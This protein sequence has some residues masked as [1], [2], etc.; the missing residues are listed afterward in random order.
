M[1]KTSSK[2]GH[3]TKVQRCSTR[4][5]SGT[6]KLTTT[7]SIQASL[8][9]ARLIYATGRASPT[10]RGRWQ[11]VLTRHLRQL[12]SGRY[13]LTLRTLHGRDTIVQHTTI[14]II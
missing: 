13:T 10:G 4:L 8:R 9:R 1:T 12:R 7:G 3:K 14:T 6:V 11:L 5:V 2:H